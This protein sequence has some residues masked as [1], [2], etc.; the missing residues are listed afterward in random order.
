MPEVDA[1]DLA[2]G[3]STQLDLGGFINTPQDIE[4]GDEIVFFRAQPLADQ[5]LAKTGCRH[6]D[7]NAHQN[8]ACR[9][10]VNELAFAC[11]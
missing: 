9:G 7:K 5:Q 2:D 10:L 11:H 4:L 3:E 1:F 8:V 6:Q